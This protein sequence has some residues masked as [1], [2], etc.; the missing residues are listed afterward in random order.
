MKTGDEI[1][2]YICSNHYYDVPFDLTEPLSHLIKKFER[3]EEIV[4]ACA[5]SALVVAQYQGHT[6]VIYD[7]KTNKNGEVENY[8]NKCV[9]VITN[10]VHPYLHSRILFAG[11]SYSEDQIHI[12]GM[13]L[14]TFSDLIKT[15]T[16]RSKLCYITS[17][18]GGI[19]KISFPVF[20]EK[21]DEM[22]QEVI[23]ALGKHAEKEPLSEAWISALSGIIRKARKDLLL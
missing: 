1:Y 12:G 20:R 8:Y 6:D 4:F 19:V 7:I 9:L 23:K 11:Y 13:P 18:F 17:N 2:E 15:C 14:Y 16:H 5:A 3:D 22:Y 21:I 10:I